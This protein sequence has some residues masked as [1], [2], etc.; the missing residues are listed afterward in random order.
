MKR[1]TTAGAT[2]A[3]RT[4]RRTANA[5]AKS[6]AKRTTPVHPHSVANLSNGLDPAGGLD[7][8]FAEG[9]ADAL[10]PDT[11]HRLVSEAAFQ[12]LE[13]R[14]FVDGSEVEDWGEAEDAVDHVN[15]RP[16]PDRGSR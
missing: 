10:D 15:L 16:P 11:R 7:L 2:T 4:A 13:A 8:P 12:R 6:T 3:K 1:K 9:N 14:G 5:S